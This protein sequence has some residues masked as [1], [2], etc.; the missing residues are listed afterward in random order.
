MNQAD[1]YV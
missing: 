1:I